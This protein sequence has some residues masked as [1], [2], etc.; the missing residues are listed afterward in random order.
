MKIVMEKLLKI[1]LDPEF[2]GHK[3]DWDRTG[4]RNQR[5]EVANKGKQMSFKKFCLYK[6]YLLSL[7]NLTQVEREGHFFK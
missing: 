1:T 7:V 3:D 2:K 5:W 6:I 4:E